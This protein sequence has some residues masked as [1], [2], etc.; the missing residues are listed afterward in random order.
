MPTIDR[1][2]MMDLLLAA[3]P[4]FGP[5]W[6][7]FQ[8]ECIKTPGELPCYLALADF[9]R[10]L[11]YLLHSG[12][13]GGMQRIFQV[14]EHLILEGDAYV[15]GA[16]IIGLL[17]DLQNTN[18]HNGTT[19]QQFVPYLGEESKYW[20]AKVERFWETGELI[21]DDR[22]KDAANREAIQ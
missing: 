19:P 12:E 8:E 7:E 20:W 17:E 14:I 15:S 6:K 13:T 16:T 4:S 22:P 2:A 1:G 18:L 10:H 5:Q 9:V 21:V 3:C 11:S